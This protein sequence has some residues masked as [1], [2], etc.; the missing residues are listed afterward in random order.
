MKMQF[1]IHLAAFNNNSD[2]ENSDMENSNSESDS[3]LT[4]EDKFSMVAVA[5]MSGDPN[6]RAFLL[7]LYTKGQLPPELASRAI[8]VL[9]RTPE[10]GNSTYESSSEDET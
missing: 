5:A 2:M 9:R 10:N 1:K 3:E 6:A 8:E 7:E 4:A